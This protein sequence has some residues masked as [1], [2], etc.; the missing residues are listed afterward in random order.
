VD[1]LLP[2][3]R[4]EFPEFEPIKACEAGIPVYF[5]RLAVEVLEKQP[6]TTFQS[7]FLHA[8]ALGVNTQEAIARLL[9]LDDR[10]LIAP[11]ASLLKAG[12]IQQGIPTSE[13]ERPLLLTPAGS[14]AL[15]A[16]GP[17]PV[18]RRKTGQFHFNALTWAAIPLEEATW[19]VE[20]M[21]KEGLSILPRKEHATPTL[22]VFTEKEVAYALGGAP[23]FQNTMIIALLE[24][25]KAELEYIAPVTVVLL[26]HRKTNEQRLAIYRNSIQQRPESVALQ[27][28]FENQQWNMPE[29]AAP[30]QERTLPH[31]STLPAEATQAVQELARNEDLQTT[32]E[33][34]LAEREED[35]TAT[36]DDRERQELEESIRH[37]KEELRIKREESEGLQRQLQRH[38]VEFLR[39]EQHRPFLLRALREA[40]QEVLIISPWM[41]R[42]A[43]NDELCR[44]V[45]DAIKRGVRIR[46]AYGMGKERD[47]TDAARN[48][49]NVQAVKGA[50]GRYV[51]KSLAQF[52]EMKE[53]KES[54]GTHQKILVCD[55][56]FAINGS[57]NWLSYTGQKGEGYRDETGTLHR[58]I[59]Q[60]TELANIALQKLASG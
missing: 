41:N 19:S 56:T 21:S 53:M 31:L 60:V 35:R 26:Q 39:T 49:N 50:L 12:Y 11:G 18:P 57:F 59:A 17:P 32:L 1:K 43:C 40:K 6:L 30:L 24:L 55:R 45:G 46:I 4:R 5:I 14:Q 10:D 15:T 27:R 58:D 48:R 38:Q 52:L 47:A 29:E 44:L 36:Q 8:I 33:I 34:E 7:Y 22:G 9:G 51:P 2:I 13:Q 25:K 16:N 42:R 37:L 23:A 3:I 20:H 54:S 28:S